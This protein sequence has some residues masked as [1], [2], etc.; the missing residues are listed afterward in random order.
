MK[1]SFH[2]FLFSR[3]QKLN[4]SRKYNTKFVGQAFF[5]PDVDAA[6]NGNRWK[7]PF[8]Y[9][10]NMSGP[11]RENVLQFDKVNTKNVTTYTLVI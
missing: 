10:L 5:Q 8:P 1:K 2:V 4:T 3:N 6:R 7:A 9:T 11:R